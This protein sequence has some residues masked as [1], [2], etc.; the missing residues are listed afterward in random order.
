[1]IITVII[2]IVIAYFTILLSYDL[3]DFSY[4]TLHFTVPIPQHFDIYLLAHEAPPSELTGMIMIIIII[5]YY[6]H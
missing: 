4:T 1:M 6:H 5:N 3:F 2:V